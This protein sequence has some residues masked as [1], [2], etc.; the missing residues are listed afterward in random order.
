MM[1]KR[2]I[3]EVKM[4]K[5]IERKNVPPIIRKALD[6]QLPGWKVMRSKVIVEGNKRVQKLEVEF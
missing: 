6:K 3:K 4:G 2:T 5:K 1:L